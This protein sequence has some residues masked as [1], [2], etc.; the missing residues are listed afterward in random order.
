VKDLLWLYE[1]PTA[2][3]G[4]VVVGAF[5]AFSLGGLWLTRPWARKRCNASNE[6][7]N[8]YIAVVAVFYAVLVGLIAV[9]TW[10]SYTDVEADVANEAVAVSE[11]YRDAEGYPP[12]LRAV[13]RETLRRYVHHVVEEEWPVQRRGIEP[14]AH[15]P[16]VMEVARHIASFEPATAGQ[17]IIHAECLRQ[18]NELLT[19]RR[20]RLQAVDSGLPG[21]MW[22]VMLMGAAIAI[23]MTFFLWHENLLVHSLLTAA[24]AGI[25]G[26]VIFLILSLDR[27]LWGSVS[28]DPGDFQEVLTTVMGEAPR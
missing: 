11:L 13:L 6:L 10:E 18:F 26:L 27:P 23:G 2:W 20:L 22:L 21:L 15:I 7:A 8:Y 4:V 17:Q 5:L 24:L 25:V 3:L 14:S 9:A 28:V 16:F 12:A 1:L 19:Y